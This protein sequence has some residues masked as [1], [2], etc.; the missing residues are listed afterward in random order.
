MGSMRAVAAAG[1]VCLVMAGGAGCN[2]DKADNGGGGNHPTS[3]AATPNGVDK[4]PVQEIVTRAE[5]AMNGLH[6][7]REVADLPDAG[8]DVTADDKGNCRLAIRVQGAHLEMIKHGDTLYVK[9]DSSYWKNAWNEQVAASVQSRAG[10]RYIKTSTSDK[11]FYSSGYADMCNVRK[12]LSDWTG[13]GQKRMLDLQDIAVHGVTTVDG[14]ARAVELRGTP[15]NTTVRDV[16]ASRF[17]A[18][19]GEPYVLKSVT[20][21]VVTNFKDFDKP[22]PGVPAAS[23]TVDASEIAGLNSQ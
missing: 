18:L 14:A 5:Q 17:I 7:L 10:D 20:S 19:D 15:K 9:G 3:E 6:S 1:V 16:E 23:E 22:V 21:G 13:T 8:E 12:T 4:L 2:S 11:G